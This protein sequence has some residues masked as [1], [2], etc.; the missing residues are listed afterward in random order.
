MI[1]RPLQFVVDYVNALDIIFKQISSQSLTMSQRLWFVIV[2]TG[3][4]ITGRFNWSTFERRSLREYKESALRWVF[5]HAKIAWEKILQ[6]SITL[7]LSHYDI[8]KGVLALDDSDKM[9]SR[10]TTKIAGVHK[11]RDKKT[12]GWFNGQEF[13]F[14]ILV[15]P[16]ITI[17]V[18]FC[19]YIPDPAL[20]KWK[21]MIKAQ[22]KAGIPKKERSK[23]PDPN[24][25]YPS[26]QALALELLRTFAKNHPNITIQAVLADALYGNQH[27]M[28]E[29]STITS[30]SQV[31]SQLHKNQLIR[32]RGKTIS[33]SAYFARNKGVV[34]DLIVRGGNTKE[35]T[36]SAARLW[37]KSHENKRFIIALKYKGETDYRYIVATDLSWRHMDVL[38]TYTLR[39]LVEVFIEDWKGHG[40]WN[41]LSKQHGVDGATRGVTLSLLCDHL[42]LLHPLQS[43]RFKNN[44]PGM[45]VGCLIEHINAEALV[46]SVHDIVTAEDPNQALKKFKEVLHESLPVRQTTKHLVGRDLGR[47]EPTP[48]LRYQKAA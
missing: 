30:C 47:M 27:F 10:N 37:V 2:L 12:G 31:I 4:I 24:P 46:E 38:R 25:A 20:K 8:S 3:I 17:P 13:I 40:G 44:Q 28:H 29:A 18:G 42:L 48:S 41:A 16:I 43:A 34:T 39:W 45:P 14:L 19:F 11:I 7:I 5:R 33:L 36:V 23:R 15:T 22:K 21:D 1:I 9:R 6:S 26:K 32:S 35:V